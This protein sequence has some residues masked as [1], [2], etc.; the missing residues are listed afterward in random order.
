LFVIINIYMECKK[1]I[2]SEYRL[3][4]AFE[5]IKNN[6]TISHAAR[7]AGLSYR[8]FFEKIIEHKV[9]SESEVNKKITYDKEDIENILKA[10]S[11]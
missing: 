7:I 2:T 6:K 4:K 5:E 8:E 9:L 3:K 10:I 11:N 1:I